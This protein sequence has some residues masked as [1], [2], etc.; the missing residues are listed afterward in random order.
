MKQSL[1]DIG[2]RNLIELFRPRIT[3]KALD[4]KDQAKRAAFMQRLTLA[5]LVSTANVGL[6]GWLT[7]SFQTANRGQIMAPVLALSIAY[8]GMTCYE[9]YKDATFYLEERKN[10]DLK[11]SV[12]TPRI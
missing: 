10:S 11:K 3:P 1:T 8:F 4:H 9:V 2:H 5:G 6:V 12:L 7:R